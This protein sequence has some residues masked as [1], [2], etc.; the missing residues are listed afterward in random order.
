[1]PAK[2]PLLVLVMLLLLLLLLLL[3]VVVALLLLLAPCSTGVGAS[4]AD[5]A[6]TRGCL[7]V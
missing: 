4:C 5:A 3:L 1:M 2:L 7:Q 6:T